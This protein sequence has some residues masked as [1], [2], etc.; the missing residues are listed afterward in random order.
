MVEAIAGRPSR[1]GRF[2]ELGERLLEGIESYAREWIAR[3]DGA[4]CARIAALECNFTDAETDNA[5]LVLT[6]KLIFPESRDAV[7][8]KRSAKA[9][10]NVI[11]GEAGKPLADGL[12]RGRGDDR[13]A[14]R[15]GIVGETTRG[16]ANEDLLLEENAEPF[17]GV[18]VGN[19][20]LEGAGGDVATI[21]GDRECDAAD[22]VGVTGTNEMDGGGTLTVDPTAVDGIEGPGAVEMECTGRADAAFGDRDGVERFDGVKT[23]VGEGGGRGRMGHE[24]SLAE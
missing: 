9:E 19:G 5:A 14:I 6:E 20:E 11:E 16:I 2:A 21:A 22:V 18:F 24:K 7:D 1:Q 23:D 12:E 10:A 4:T 13:W 15:D 17:G 3:R 8:F